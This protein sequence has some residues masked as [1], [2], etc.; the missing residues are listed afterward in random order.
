MPSDVTL[1]PRLTD[2]DT[3][4]EAKTQF[5]WAIGTRYSQGEQ[6]RWILI[7][8]FEHVMSSICHNK[9]FF[10]FAKNIGWAIK[11]MESIQYTKY[12]LFTMTITNEQ[13][14]VKDNKSTSCEKLSTKKIEEDTLYT[15]YWIH[16]LHKTVMYLKFSFET[17]LF[18]NIIMFINLSIFIFCWFIIIFV[19]VL[20]FRSLISDIWFRTIKL[21]T[22]TWNGRRRN[23]SKK[24]K[25][26]NNT[27]Y[28]ET[29]ESLSPCLLIASMMA[30][31]PIGSNCERWIEKWQVFT[32]HNQDSHRSTKFISK[33]LHT[34][35]Y[36]RY[37]IHLSISM[38]IYL[39]N[40][41]K[42]KMARIYTLIRRHI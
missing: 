6:G 18:T 35:I 36:P 12:R 42:Y 19:F 29:K 30:K 11:M 38:Y 13:P 41:Y 39:S 15:S 40:R 37:T 2:E 21:T 9:F 32:R 27:I 26:N 25:K 28:K 23:G 34:H 7:F 14:K 3:D 33:P 16:T 1:T 22:E 31:D 4:D 24:K 10:F 17:L 5:I 20:F 8:L